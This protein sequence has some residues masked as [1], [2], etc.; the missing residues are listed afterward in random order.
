MIV[1]VQTS[2]LP[3]GGPDSLLATSPPGAVKQVNSFEVCLSVSAGSATVTPYFWSY[4]AWYPLGDDI[5]APKSVTANFAGVA[6]AC[7]RFVVPAVPRVWAFL[8]SGAGTV[9][10]CGVDEGPIS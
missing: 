7:A 1:A 9:S 8:K 4:G 5:T 10:V 6:N 3:V 2:P